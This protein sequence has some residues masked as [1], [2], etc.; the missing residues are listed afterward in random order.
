MLHSP[1]HLEE[2]EGGKAQLTQADICS[3]WYYKNRKQSVSFSVSLLHPN[4]QIY[5]WHMLKL[6]HWHS[7]CSLYFRFMHISPASLYILLSVNPKYW[8]PSSII[9]TVFSMT[10]SGIG[11]PSSQFQSDHFA[12]RPLTWLV[13]DVFQFWHFVCKT[14]LLN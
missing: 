8:V 11:L 3:M 4:R 7:P 5:E 2:K 14:A 9:S 10:Q 6:S 13:I 12:T 1:I